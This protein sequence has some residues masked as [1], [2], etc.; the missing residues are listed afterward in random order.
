MSR[1]APSLAVII[2]AYNAAA[3]LDRTLQS[4][5]T[6][7]AYAKSKLELDAEIIVVDDR[8]TDDTPH[9]VKRWSEKERAVKL[10][11]NAA[12][13]GPGFSR[14]EGVRQTAAQFLFFLDADDVFYENHI[15]TCLTALLADDT[16]G[17]VFTRM[18]ID[19]PMHAEWRESLDESCPINFCVRRVWHDWIKGF[20]EEEDFRTYRTEDTL[21]RMCLRK[22]V[23]HKKIDIETC[24]QFVSPGNALARQRQKLSM[25]KA[26]FAKSGISDGFVMTEQMKQVSLDRLMHVEKLA[27]RA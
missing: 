17:Y 5:V 27:G 23:K 12:N 15:H 18:K 25:S 19:I 20:P 10:H 1:F 3:T 26:E 22:L 8:S 4:A 6:S 9:I 21:Y 24:E 14:N 11:I 16:V 2:P 7:L 13:R